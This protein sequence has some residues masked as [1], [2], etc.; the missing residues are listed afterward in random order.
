M[1][2]KQ[3]KITQDWGDIEV[4]LDVDHDKLT[5]QLADEINRFWIN[6]EE[7]LEAADGDAVLAVIRLA[8]A[9]FMDCGLRWESVESA[10]RDLDTSE[11]WPT[12]HGITLVS[13]D[14]FPDIVS[15]ELQVAE[16]E[17]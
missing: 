11:G 15:T 13:F 6:H 7:R 8:A 4:E 5:P 10:Q 3:Y 2:I 17:S 12:D 16:I 1:N 9:H 14:G